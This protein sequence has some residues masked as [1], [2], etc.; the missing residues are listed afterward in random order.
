RLSASAS[1]LVRGQA[2]AVF[3]QQARPQCAETSSFGTPRE[4][5]PM[6]QMPTTLLPNGQKIAQLGL[7]TWQMGE[8][9]ARRAEEVKSLKIGLD[10]GMTVV[11]TAEMYASGGAEEIVSEAIDGRRDGVY[12]V[13]KVL[14]QNSS[15]KGTVT[16]CERSLKRLKTDRL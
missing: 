15:A 2:A 1:C 9:R 10:L 13:S 6:T 5:C 11:D 7:G 8:S 16:A 4:D 3:D 12:L 14:P